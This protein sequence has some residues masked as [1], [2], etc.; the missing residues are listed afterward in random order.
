MGLADANTTEIDQT[1]R[2]PVVC[3]LDEQFSITDMGGTMRLGL[4]PCKV[5]E[6]SLAQRSYGTTE[7][8][9]RHRHRYEFNSAYRARFEENGFRFSGTS[10]DGQL[11]EI[12]ELPS[13][14]WFW[15]FSVTRNS[16]QNPRAPIRFS[17]VSYPLPSLIQGTKRDLFTINTIQ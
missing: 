11:V 16:V 14:P 8:N 2:N 1:T 3:L 12:V 17:R 6:G 9:E 15:L 10:P 13:H 5:E 7:A 4:Y